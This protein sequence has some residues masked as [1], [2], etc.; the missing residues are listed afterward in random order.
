MAATASSAASYAVSYDSITNFSLV[1][2]TSATFQGL[3]ASADAA[4]SIGALTGFDVNGAFQDASPA[5][6]GTYCAGFNNSFTSHLASPPP[7][8]SYG[9]ANIYST[10]VTGGAGSASSIGEAMAFDGIAAAAGGNK[11]VAKFTLDSSDTLSFSFKATPYMNTQMGGGALDALAKTRMAISI[12]QGG[13]T[14]FQWS[15]NGLAG[16]ITGG[17]ELSDPF[18]LNLDISGNST[19]T[20]SLGS[21]SAETNLLGAGTYYMDIYM[22][23][24]AEVHAVPV[25]AALPLFGSGV[26]TLAALIRRRRALA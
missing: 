18:S 1:L 10:N 26:V 7:G 23:N 17:T 15:P 4:I 2:P 8:Y 5:C 3:T 12:R 21:F 19:Y 20:N 11:M 6:V 14:L 9:D 13:T 24:L 25:P 22:T 16:G